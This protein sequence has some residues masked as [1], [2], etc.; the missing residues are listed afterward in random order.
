MCWPHVPL[1]TPSITQA[2][3]WATRFLCIP[4]IE[5]D[6]PWTPIPRL[7]NAE[8]PQYRLVLFVEGKRQMIEVDPTATLVPFTPCM[9][10][11]CIDAIYRAVDRAASQRRQSEIPWLLSS[12]GTTGPLMLLGVWGAS[13]ALRFR[14]AYDAPSVILGSIVHLAIFYLFRRRNETPPYTLLQ[15]MAI[16]LL[17]SWYRQALGPDMGDEGIRVLYIFSVVHIAFFAL[18]VMWV[19]APCVALGVLS[20]VST[21]S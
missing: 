15:S 19:F 1:D 16:T 6:P 17:C 8:H 13:A 11:C 4:G 3:V 7:T 2:P 5:A 21:F 12:F 9:E 14:N 18:A 10:E 20:L